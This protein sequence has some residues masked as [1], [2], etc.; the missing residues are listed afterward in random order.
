MMEIN[1]TWRMYDDLPP[2]LGPVMII[3]RTLFSCYSRPPPGF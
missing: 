3:W 1:A 2:M